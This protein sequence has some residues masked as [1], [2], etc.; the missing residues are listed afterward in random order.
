MFEVETNL[1]LQQF[2]APWILAWMQILSEAGKA[3]VYSMLLLALAFGFRLR[4][5][6]GV[7]LALV[8]AG[9]ATDTVKQGFAFP[10][11][12]EVDARVLDKG[13]EG[14]HLV[15]YGAATTFWSLPTEEAIDAARA[16]GD[17]DYGFLSGHVAEAGAWAL[18][19]IGLLRLRRRRWVLLLLAWPILIAI[20][21]LYLGRHFLADVLG[22]LVVGGAAAAIAITLMRE[23]SAS[24]A[25][26]HRAWLVSGVVALVLCGLSFIADPLDPYQAGSVAGALV[27]IGWLEWRGWPRDEASPVRRGLRAAVCMVFVR[28]S[29]WLLEQLHSLGAWPDG[30]RVGYLFALVGFPVSI[31]GA[32]WLAQALGLYGVSGKDGRTTPFESNESAP[33]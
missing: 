20:S 16:T 22:G 14:K 21:R 1:W 10:R 19:L 23:I 33:G 32:V 26:A 28:V 18:A 6:L 17:H 27:C 4:P 24:G 13:R 25:S 8:L 7:M 9:V 29:G 30:S 5:M 3:V 31:L 12:S 11:P 15:A 2:N